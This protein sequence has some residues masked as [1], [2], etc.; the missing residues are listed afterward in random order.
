MVSLRHWSKLKHGCVID[1]EIFHLG[2]SPF[3]NLDLGLT[4]VNYFAVLHIKIILNIP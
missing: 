4:D 3:M 1:P 2:H